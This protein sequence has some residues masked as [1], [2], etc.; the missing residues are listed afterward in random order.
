MPPGD[1][2]GGI[3]EDEVPGLPGDCHEKQALDVTGAQRRSLQPL[4]WN[5]QVGIGLRND[6]RDW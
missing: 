2:N 4:R 6:Q 3:K 5:I 1:K